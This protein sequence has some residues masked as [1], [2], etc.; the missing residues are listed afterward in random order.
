MMPL[1]LRAQTGL[2]LAE[3]L[4]AMALGLGILLGAS[5][6]LV[7]SVRSHAALRETLAMDEN[8]HFALSLLARSVQQAALVDGAA[9]VAPTPRLQ[10]LDASTLARTD[11]ALAPGGAPAINGSDVLAVRF[12]GTGPGPDGD[13]AT[14]DCAGLSIGQQREGWSIFH[15]AR[16]AQGVAELRCKYQGQG[17]WSSEAIISGIDGFQVLYGVDT[18]GD[19]APN[20]YLNASTL[21]QLDGAA[22]AG[23]ASHWHQVVSVRVALLLPGPRMAFGLDGPGQYQLFGPGYGDRAGDVGTTLLAVDLV[24]SNGQARLRR[25]YTRTI[26]IGGPP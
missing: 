7:A 19:G 6:F 12:P 3:L 22:P 15:V 2:G 21:T 13:G 11:P 14:R 25:I 5:S 10:G 20:G 9:L 1:R 17:G 4:V 24:E 26:A 18:D 8:A 16:D 23:Q